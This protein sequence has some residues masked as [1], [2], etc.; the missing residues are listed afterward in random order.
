M[1]LS[2]LVSFPVAVNF[3]VSKFANVNGKKDVKTEESNATNA[4]S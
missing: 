1:T 2:T 3:A 4:V